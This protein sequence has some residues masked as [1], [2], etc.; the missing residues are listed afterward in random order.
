[1]TSRT[2]QDP[3]PIRVKRFHDGSYAIS[4][5]DRESGN[6]TMIEG[7]QSRARI[8]QVQGEYWKECV[9]GPIDFSPESA[10]R[11]VAF[12]GSTESA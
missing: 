1:M 9:T 2:A 10:S 12:S 8:V 3:T 5:I 6:F 7:S 11:T 4:V